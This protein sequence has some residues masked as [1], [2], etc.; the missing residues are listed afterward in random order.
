M[1][2]NV[3]FRKYE[4]LHMDD[5]ID[6]QKDIWPVEDYDMCIIDTYF[7]YGTIRGVSLEISDNEDFEKS[8]TFQQQLYRRNGY[9]S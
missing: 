4:T 7:L 1:A 9:S 5:F 2:I 3:P 6:R 8:R